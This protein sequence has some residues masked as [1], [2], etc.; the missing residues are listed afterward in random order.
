[1]HNICV[2]LVNYARKAVSITRGFTCTD[3]YS[4]LST[5]SNTRDN[6]PII[7]TQTHGFTQQLSLQYYRFSPLLITDL[8][9]VSTAP[10]IRTKR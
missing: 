9:T 4:H 7:L 1:M 6:S 3:I 2:Q 10:I 5:T 8:F